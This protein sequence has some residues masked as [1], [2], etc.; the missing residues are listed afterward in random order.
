MYFFKKKIAICIKKLLERFRGYRNRQP[1]ESELRE[2][3]VLLSSDSRDK[4]KSESLETYR[5]RKENCGFL[6]GKRKGGTVWVTD[7][8]GPGKKPCL[9]AAMCEP[10]YSVLAPYL[11]R[12]QNVVGEWHLHPGYGAG[13]SSGDESTLLDASAI[14][15]GFVA[16]VVNMNANDIWNMAAF[17]AS[18]GQVVNMKLEVDDRLA[19]IID[20]VDTRLLY[21][22]TVAVLGGGS[23]GSK[24]AEM[25][26]RTGIGNF[27]LVDLATEKLE[28]V[29]LTRHIGFARDL[30]KPKTKVIAKVLKLINSKVNV[31]IEHFDIAEDEEKLI[32]VVS[33]SDLV[34][35]CPGDPLANAL[36]NKVCLQLKKPAVFAGAFE[37]GKGGYIFALDPSDENAACFSCLFGFSGMPDSNLLVRRAARNYGIDESQLHAQQGLCLDT[38]QIAILQ[39]RQALRMLLKGTRYEVANIKGNVIWVDNRNLEIRVLP[40]RRREDCYACNRKKWLAGQSQGGQISIEPATKNSIGPA[41]KK[42]NKFLSVVSRAFAGIKAIK[43]KIST[44]QV[45]RQENR[46]G[47]TH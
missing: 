13:L 45:E 1:V 40:V 20:L 37:R 31:K 6:L 24:C 39:T 18:S 47:N 35:A 29:N 30:G 3:T 14:I 32:Q 19:R 23:G 2:P 17:S 4:I 11:A 7:A 44:A 21:S 28:K 5:N 16:L 10:D 46:H 12:G 38:T 34:L 26:A 43:R 33:A 27:I 8:T 42:Q 9:R 15:P 36:I 41:E 25:C 22:K